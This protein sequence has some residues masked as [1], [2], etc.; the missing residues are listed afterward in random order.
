MSPLSSLFVNDLVF[1]GIHGSTGREVHDQQRFRISIVVYLDITRAAV[2]DN[3][4]DTYDY[5]DATEIARS[6]VEGE[7]YVL[8]EKIVS[9]IAERVCQNPVVVSVDV[10]VEKLDAHTHAIPG[11]SVCCKRIPQEM[12][13]LSQSLLQ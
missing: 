5:K 8:I 2:T 7:Q 12:V 4:R 13:L 10:K 1:S 11:I 9:R 6:V 3:I